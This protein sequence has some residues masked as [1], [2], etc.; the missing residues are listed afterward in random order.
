MR[1]REL[2]G[3]AASLAA[4]ACGSRVAKDFEA[5]AQLPDGTVLLDLV[6]CTSTHEVA[7]PTQL[8]LCE[9]LSSW[10]RSHLSRAGFDS[11]RLTHAQVTLSLDT[12]HPPTNRQAIVSFQLLAVAS[13]GVGDHAYVAS[14]AAHH[15]HNRAA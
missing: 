10:L 11:S 9:E 6:A 8:R 15:W 4:I 13:L 2:Q 5:L 14:S 3:V 12:S 7:G 1:T